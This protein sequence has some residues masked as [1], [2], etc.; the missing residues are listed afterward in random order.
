MK[1][2]IRFPPLHRP[3]QTLWLACRLKN[4][5][6]SSTEKVLR[7]TTDIVGRHQTRLAI[8]GRL[9]CK[10]PNAPTDRLADYLVKLSAEARCSPPPRGKW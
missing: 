3:L 6:S 5:S 4:M 7:T 9:N 2:T 8:S 1:W 10:K